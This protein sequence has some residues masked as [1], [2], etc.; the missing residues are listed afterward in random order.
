MRLNHVAVVCSSQENADRFY[1]GVLGLQ[2]IKTS[3]LSEELARQ[4][5][6]SPQKCQII[7]Y[8]SETFAVEVFVPASPPEKKAPFA[9][10]CLEWKMPGDGSSGETHR[11]GGFAPH[12]CS[13][14]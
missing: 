7:L 1:E 4:I 11:K 10:L 9:H 8:A 3:P 6:D 14:L 2:K 5:F 12:I 13:G